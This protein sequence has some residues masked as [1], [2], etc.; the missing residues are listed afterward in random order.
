VHYAAIKK[1][2]RKHFRRIINNNNYTVYNERYALLVVY[3]IVAAVFVLSKQ[4][5]LLL[6]DNYFIYT[7]NSDLNE[8]SMPGMYVILSD[9]FK[10]VFLIVALIYCKKKYNKHRNKIYLLLAASSVAFNMALNTGGTRIRMVFALILGVYF[11]VYVFGKIPKILYIF[12]AVLC[13]VSFISVSTVKFSYAIGDSTNLVTA[14]LTIMSGQFQDYFAGPRLIG[15]MIEVHKIYGNRIS[16]STFINDFTGSIPIISNSVNQADRI[17]YYFNIYCNMNNQTLIAPVLGIGYCYCPAFPFFFSIIFE[18]F[19]IKLD[20]KMTITNQL[21]YKYLY[22]YMGY[23]C[24]MCM[25]YSTQNIYAQF[26]SA[27]IPLLV[28]FKLNNCLQI[29]IVQYRKRCGEEK[30]EYSSNFYGRGQ[31][32]N[33]KQR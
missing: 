28:L 17:N 1:Y 12:G 25:G 29:G 5:A 15:Q 14:V 3:I 20:Y 27:F 6:M 32:R 33:A 23:V 18:Y 7:G 22:A 21:T 2:S 24:G 31:F 10:K 9:T 19:V 11:L 13:L 4:P 26:V 8:T 30:I 16:I